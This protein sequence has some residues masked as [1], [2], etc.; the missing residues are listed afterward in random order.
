MADQF[1]DFIG[2]INMQLFVF[3]YFGVADKFI[4]FFAVIKFLDR[5]GKGINNFAIAQSYFHK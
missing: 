4:R 3:W 1:V 2:I 5:R